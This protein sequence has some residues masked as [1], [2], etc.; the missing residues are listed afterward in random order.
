MS[1]PPLTLKQPA[2]MPGH[3]LLA[4]LG[5]RVLR[6]GGMKLTHWMLNS[7]KI[8][9]TDAVVEFA[10]GMGATA[11]LTLQQNPASY[12]AIERDENAANMVRKYL[13]NETQQC[14]IASAENTGLPAN[15]ATVV[16]GEAM[17]TMQ[18]LQRKQQIIAEAARLLKAGGRYG[19]HEI[20]F[21][22]DG[23]AAETKQK[24]Q[25]E[26]A[27]VIHHGTMP[28]T[29]TEWRDLL[30]ATGLKVEA[31]KIVPMHLLEPLR[32]LEDEGIL[33]TLRFAGNLLRY[34]DARK[35]VLAMRRVFHKYQ[36]Y[37]GAMSLIS[38]K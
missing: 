17:L 38:V 30:A 8:N 26:I 31:E 32:I 24:I 23:L 28:L 25:R 35:Q 5:K 37:L 7:L 4:K 15:S 2:K 16:Y 19:I 27:E 9:S 22:A 3:W 29:A 11:Q 1:Y 36:P 21:V 14:F 18:P 12:I 6:P 20:C 34:P 10:P 13:T 33:G